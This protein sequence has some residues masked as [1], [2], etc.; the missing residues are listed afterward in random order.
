MTLK[1][2]FEECKKLQ[3]CERRD[4]TDEYM[5][6]VFYTRDVALWNALFSNILGPAVKAAGIKASLDATRLA[7]RFG[8]IWDNQTLYKKDIESG[9]IMVM[10]WPWQDSKHTTAKLA[11]LKK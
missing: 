8:G 11:Y 6:F 9:M 2:I 1:E 10:F 7:G 3:I 4:M 5:E